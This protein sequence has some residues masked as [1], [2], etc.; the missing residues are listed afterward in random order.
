MMKRQ[1]WKDLSRR[2]QA[3]IGAAGLVQL[4]L[5]GAT[6]VDLSRRP[7][8]QVRGSKKAWAAAAFVNF[9]GPLAY[10]AFGRRRARS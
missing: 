7:G 4:L 9:V 5:L 1:R 10:F 2:Q 8:A 6:L 3:A